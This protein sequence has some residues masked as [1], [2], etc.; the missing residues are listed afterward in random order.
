MGYSILVLCLYYFDLK[1][2]VYEVRSEKQLKGT[3]CNPLFLSMC[4]SK[5]ACEEL[6]HKTSIGRVSDLKKP[7]FNWIKE[8]IFYQWSPRQIFF[9]KLARYACKSHVRQ[10]C[11]VQLL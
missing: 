1:I 10:E 4:T 11:K 3:S 7:H 2:H 9:K 5:Q 6:I 8:E